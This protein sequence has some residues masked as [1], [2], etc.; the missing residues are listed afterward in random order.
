MERGADVTVTSHPNDP[1]ASGW[2]A[3]FRALDVDQ[4][5]VLSRSEARSK[6]SVLQQFAALDTD[7]DGSLSRS[8]TEHVI[9]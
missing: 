6:A 5:G 4:D 7:R 3:E 8:E 9:N 2:R 1:V